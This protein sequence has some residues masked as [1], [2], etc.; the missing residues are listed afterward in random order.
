MTT[1]SATVLRKSD[2]CSKRKMRRLRRRILIQ[3][4][5]RLSSYLLL[6]RHA[7]SGILALVCRHGCKHLLFAIDQIGSVQGRDLKAM[8]VSDGV[9]RTGLDAI[10]AEDA[11]VVVDVIDL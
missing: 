5:L 1:R 9:R 11:A 2:I 7:E 3:I 10:S 8:A 6:V 4:L